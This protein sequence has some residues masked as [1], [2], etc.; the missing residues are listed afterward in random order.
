MASCTVQ[1]KVRVAATVVATTAT[2]AMT[3]AAATAAMT[4]AVAAAAVVA[5]ARMITVQYCKQTQVHAV[6]LATK[7]VLVCRHRTESN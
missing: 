2:A 3:A 6:V 4:A 1:T 5:T 7:A